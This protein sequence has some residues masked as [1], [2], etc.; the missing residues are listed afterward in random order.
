MS[1]RDAEQVVHLQIFWYKRLLLRNSQLLAE[2]EA[3]AAID[4]E[5]EKTL[6]GGESWKKM[7]MLFMQL[8]K[9]SLHPFLLPSAE[10]D[11]D[12]TTSDEII[13]TSGKMQV[14][15]ILLQ[16]LKKAGHRVIIFS[17]FTRMLDIVE[18]FCNLRAHKH[19]RLDGSTNR[20]QRWVNVTQFNEK[21]SNIFVF[22]LS[23]RAGGL[24][25]NLQTADT[26]ILLDSDW[27]PQVD[28]QA[29]ARVHRIGQKKPVHV[30]RLIS[31]ETIEG[32]SRHQFVSCA[33]LCK[34]CNHTTTTVI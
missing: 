10:S 9:I 25:V 8:R 26:V 11:F 6:D 23:T 29:M 7:K 21:G 24:G 1:D 4:P 17:Q 2:L 34:I 28:R 30:Y 5:L 31:K 20:V 13:E 14:L 33:S 15:D 19:V 12:G 32:N 22:L 18:D 16:A 3:Q 27:N